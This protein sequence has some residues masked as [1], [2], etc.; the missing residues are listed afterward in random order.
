[1]RLNADDFR[2]TVFWVER[3]V[4][5]FVPSLRRSNNNANNQLPLTLFISL[6]SSE[7]A[8]AYLLLK[9]G[10]VRQGADTSSRV[11]QIQKKAVA[12]SV[13]NL[14]AIMGLKTVP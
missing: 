2:I 9:R 7:A 14:S 1:M 3:D 8:A 13:S 6:F 10:Q 4:A 12:C 5:Y 11:S